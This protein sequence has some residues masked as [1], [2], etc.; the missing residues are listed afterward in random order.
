MHRPGFTSSP[1]KY[2]YGVDAPQRRIIVSEITK[3]N[4]AVSVLRIAGKIK[5]VLLPSTTRERQRHDIFHHF[6]ELRL[7]A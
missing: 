7:N 3:L 5:S 6:F 4:G 1:K 2:R